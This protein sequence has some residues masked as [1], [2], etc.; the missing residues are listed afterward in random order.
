MLENLKSEDFWKIARRYFV[1]ND[2]RIRWHFVGQVQTK[3]AKYLIGNFHLIH[4]VD[5]TKLADALHSRAES[6]EIKQ[7]VLLQ[8]NISGESS[9][10]GVQPEGL[11][12]LVRHIVDNCNCLH[13]Q[14]LMGM[15][16]LFDQGEAARPYFAKLRTLKQ[17]IEQEF[18]IQMP[19]LSMGMSG[20]F[21]SAIQEGSTLVRIGTNIFGERE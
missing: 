10:A 9:K 2:A 1:L 19:H 17:E 5:R 3:K 18:S 14:G 13:L 7:P 15:P 12:N 11:K 6:E 8:V 4:A 16:A 20:D 21:S